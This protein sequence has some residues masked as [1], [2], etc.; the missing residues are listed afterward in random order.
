M[1]TGI[2]RIER[3]KCLLKR[4][5]RSKWCLEYAIDSMRA[6]HPYGDHCHPKK[7]RPVHTTGLFFTTQQC[8]TPKDQHAVASQTFYAERAKQIENVELA[9]TVL[10]YA[11]PGKNLSQ[12]TVGP[13]FGHRYFRTTSKNK[14]KLNEARQRTANSAISIMRPRSCGLE[15]VLHGLLLDL[16]RRVIQPLHLLGGQLPAQRPQIFSRLRQSLHPHDRHGALTNAPVQGHLRHGLAAS[17]R[18]LSHHG[19]Q[20]AHRR[21]NPAENNPAGPGGNVARVVLSRQEP[22]PQRGVGDARDPEG[23]GGLEKAVVEGVSGN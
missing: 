6:L 22:Q 4:T 18:Y 12:Y 10:S 17:L 9:P 11:L 19:E 16:P 21:Q 20:R 5:Y 8:H 13:Q 2:L 3:A 14:K 1:Q 15:N 7:L 23:F